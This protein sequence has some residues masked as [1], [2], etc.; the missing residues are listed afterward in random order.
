MALA[1]Q[2]NT[3]PSR[4]R[5]T[6]ASLARR[7]ALSGFVLTSGTFSV[8]GIGRLIVTIRQTGGAPGAVLTLATRIQGQSFDVRDT[9]TV[10]ALNTTYTMEVPLAAS[11]AQIVLS[12][13]VGVA[14]YVATLQ[15][16]G[17]T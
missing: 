14:S 9:V 15:G 13:V 7:I 6:S 5:V 3:S 2:G 11:D 16:A 8:L 10:A 17:T 1:P 12:G 4:N